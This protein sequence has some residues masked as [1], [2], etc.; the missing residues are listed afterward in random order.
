MEAKKR[1]NDD[2][3]WML[4]IHAWDERIKEKGV[5]D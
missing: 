5:A 2:V 1:W 3:G 4:R